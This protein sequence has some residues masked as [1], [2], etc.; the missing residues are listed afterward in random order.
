[1]DSN[2]VIQNRKQN[3]IDNI[4]V[5]I[6]RRII[7]YGWTDTIISCPEDLY[8]EIKKHF[9]SNGFSFWREKFEYSDA[10]GYPVGEYGYHVH[11]GI[12]R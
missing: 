10:D 7:K 1:M 4:N 9:E 5:K 2:Q 6:Q 11:V 3:I 8:S 12:K